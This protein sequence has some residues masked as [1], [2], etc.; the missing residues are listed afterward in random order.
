MNAGQFRR[1]WRNLKD[2]VLP[3]DP[4]KIMDKKGISEIDFFVPL[5]MFR[6][7]STWSDLV[8][9]SYCLPESYEN[10]NKND[11]LI[12]KVDKPLM[13]EIQT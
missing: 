2:V 11:Y 5:P 6:D 8:L 3:I 7:I 4:Q 12:S 9:L 1:R 10:N 13:L